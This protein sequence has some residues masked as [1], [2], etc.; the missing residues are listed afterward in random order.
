MN[1]LTPNGLYSYS[2]FG[3]KLSWANLKFCYIRLVLFIDLS[4]LTMTNFK[5]YGINQSG[6]KG[7]HPCIA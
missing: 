4:L 7:N 3:D 1:L 6:K 2:W 5:I